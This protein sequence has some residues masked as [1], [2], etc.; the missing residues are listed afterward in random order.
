MGEVNPIYAH[1]EA[2]N[3]PVVPKLQQVTPEGQ[4]VTVQTYSELSGEE[5]PV[6]MAELDGSAGSRP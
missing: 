3:W 6:E 5:R 2:P 4:I 1:P